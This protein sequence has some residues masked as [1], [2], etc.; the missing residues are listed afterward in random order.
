MTPAPG[1]A[2]SFE[3]ASFAY[4]RNPVLTGVNVRV[5]PGA[6]LALVG[7]NGAGKSTFLKGVLGLVRVVAGSAEVLGERPGE[8]V[9][10]I[11]YMPQSDE[12]DPE[13]PVTLRQVVMMGRYRQ[14]GWLRLPGRADR[15]AVARVLDEVGLTRLANARFGELSG[16]QKQRGLLARALVSAPRILLLDEPFNGLDQTNRDALIRILK[17]L[18]E[19]GVA[20][21][22]STHDLELARLVC[23]EV[24]LLNHR[25]IAYGPV[26]ETLTLEQIE[27]AYSLSM[28]DEA[29]H[30]GHGAKAH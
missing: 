22:V 17:N 12:L 14:I 26:D 27:A 16:G 13:F 7:P 24:V 11:G 6:A 10:R 29:A 2:I 25:Q 8:A 9:G 18:R 23:D 28:Q 30:C 15:E 19:A 21:V 1:P 4:T 5:R 3:N 20:I